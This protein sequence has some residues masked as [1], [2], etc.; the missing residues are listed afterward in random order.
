MEEWQLR[1]ATSLVTRCPPSL[2]AACPAA[3]PV[4]GRAGTVAKNDQLDLLAD[5]MG[6]GEQVAAITNS[7]RRGRLT[8]REGAYAQAGLKAVG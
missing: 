8:P 1:C 2:F 6:V 7:V 4:C 3:R 5:F